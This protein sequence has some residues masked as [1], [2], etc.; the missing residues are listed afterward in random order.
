MTVDIAASI[1]DM[2]KASMEKYL[3][4]VIDSLGLHKNSYSVW[5]MGGDSH[6]IGEIA[7]KAWRAGISISEDRFAVIRQFLL[8]ADNHI[9][10][11]SLW[12]HRGEKSYYSQDEYKKERAAA[13]K[14]L[15]ITKPTNKKESRNGNVQKT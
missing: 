14:V 4:E 9:H 3:R 1:L 13:E 15:N 2:D 5:S 11:S 6:V 12:F 8:L 10:V 7:M